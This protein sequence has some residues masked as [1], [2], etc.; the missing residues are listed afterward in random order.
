MKEKYEEMY[1]KAGGRLS[2]NQEMKSARK[3]NLWSRVSVSKVN[4]SQLSVL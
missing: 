3:S 1:S 2:V 4:A